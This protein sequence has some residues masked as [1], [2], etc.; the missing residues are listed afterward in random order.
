[1]IKECI[2]AVNNFF[3]ADLI[4]FNLGAD[5][6]LGISLLAF[7][8]IFVGLYF[9]VKTGFLPIKFLPEIMT[10]VKENLKVKNKSSISGVQALIVS[11]ASR[12]GM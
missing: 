11:T 10:Q 7:L 4:K 9:F 8:L 2:N 5:N 3:W 6:Q 1:M 12:V